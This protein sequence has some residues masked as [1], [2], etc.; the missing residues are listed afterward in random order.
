M[1][2]FTKSAVTR[3]KSEKTILSVLDTVSRSDNRALLQEFYDTTLESLRDAQ[4]EVL[5]IR[6]SR[7]VLEF[8][9]II[10]FM[11]C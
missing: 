3:N 5:Y 2:V 8:C 7:N 1:L 4:N 10:C 11:Y 9:L 6:M